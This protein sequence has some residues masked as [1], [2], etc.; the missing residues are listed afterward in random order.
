MQQATGKASLQTEQQQRPDEYPATPF[1]IGLN[2]LNPPDFLQIDDDLL[3]YRNLKQEYYRSIFD[4][5]C[6]A[7][8]QS[9][10]AQLESSQLLVENLRAY[11]AGVYTFSGGS[12]ESGL[13]MN[14]ATCNQTGET[15]SLS[16]GLPIAD[17][18]LLIPDDL[19][20]MSRDETGWRLTAASLSFPSSW[21]LKDKF[22][23]CMDRIHRPVPLSLQMG[24]RITRIFDS[25]RPKMP[26][27]R[28]NWS[29][30]GNGELRHERF[31]NQ[32]RK[33]GQRLKGN[34]HLRTEFQTLHK[35]PV[36]GDI[37]F[38]IRIRSNPITRFADSERGRQKLVMLHRQY[39]AMSD[40]ERDY[41]GINRNAEGLMAWLEEVER[42]SHG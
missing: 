2:L 13:D 32:P 26:V 17:I 7:E 38:T 42:Q 24:S 19:V 18:G 1:R 34:V 8:K 3:P 35:L 9:H 6:V 37:L 12:S 39:L 16:G 29:L 28:S 21:S 11:H 4:E 27:W 25:L 5:V 22:S 30:D 15:F 20:L 14:R 36:S 10:A 31:E 40:A 33:S 41:K 23:K